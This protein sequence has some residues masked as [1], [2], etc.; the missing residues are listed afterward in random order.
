MNYLKKYFFLFLAGLF[1]NYAQPS[2]SAPAE[3]GLVLDNWF[4]LFSGDP[5]DTWHDPQDKRFIDQG[6]NLTQFFKDNTYIREELHNLRQKFINIYHD[7]ENQP[8]A[9]YIQLSKDIT[10]ATMNFTAKYLERSLP[11]SVSKD[12]MAFIGFG[13]MA[14]GESGVITDLEG[15]LVW[16]DLV[17]GKEALS[18]V[19]SQTLSNLLDG[20]LGHPIYGIKGFRLDEAEN[21]PFHRAPWAKNMSLKQAYCM[22]LK[23]LPM[24]SNSE[25][26]ND[27]TKSYF[28]PFEGSWAYATTPSQLAAYTAAANIK[29]P[30]FNKFKINEENKNSDWYKWGS[31]FLKLTL[32]SPGYI[33]RVLESADC[34]RDVDKKSTRDYA[35]SLSNKMKEI[36]L[37]VIKNFPLLGRNRVFVYGN[38]KLFDEFENKRNEILNA[39]NQKLRKS[40]ARSYLSTVAKSFSKTGNGM[41][42]NGELPEVIDVKRQNYRLEEQLLTNL[43]FLYDLK[44]QNQGDIIKDLVKRGVFSKEYGEQSLKRVNQMIRLRWKKQILVESQLSANMQFITKEAH[45]KKIEDLKNDL[46]RNKNIINNVDNK[47]S[48]IEI[49][50]AKADVIEIEQDL[51]KMPKLIPG[52]NDSVFSPADI[53]YI[54]DTLL[55]GQVDLLKRLK[56][57][58]GSDEASPDPDAFKH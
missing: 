40:L 54:K 17:S 36:E 53:K 57:F 51:H 49:L 10:K 1:I 9:D 30:P 21:S 50:K 48:K 35:N 25:E 58:M 23:S 2:L 4:D 6:I 45:S 5:L 22:A 38:K 7:L 28:Y 8:D 37:G 44:S 13:S 18:M 12:E 26:I 19:F 11:A 14:R 47:Y 3:H 52:N 24:D 20:L 55:P 42:I 33:N 31:N 16:D 43:G 39:D 46:V 27:F 29:W 15:A 56:R 41:F 34:M 32:L